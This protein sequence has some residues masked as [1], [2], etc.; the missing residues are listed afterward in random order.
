MQINNNEHLIFK[1]I[2]DGSSYIILF[3]ASF[4]FIE[5]LVRAFMLPLTLSF[6]L[7]R[8]DIVNE[9]LGGIEAANYAYQNIMGLGSV[10]VQVV[11][12]IF[13][14]FAIVAICNKV[15]VNDFNNFKVRIGNNIGMILVFG[16][17]IYVVDIIVSNVYAFLGEG[18]TSMNQLMI[19]GLLSSPARWLTI[20]LTVLLA[21]IVEEMVFRKFMFGV[22][23]DKLKFPIW[24]SGLLSAIVFA[25][26]HV[27][28]SLDQLI[29]FPQYFV[30]AIVLV[31]AYVY[32]KQNIW[33][34][35]G[36]HIFNNAVSVILWAISTLI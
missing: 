32:S 8:A 31:G 2:K 20:L 25:L 4:V 14:I 16:V 26:I 3:L 34:S 15:L 35:I 22:F 27:S 17:A 36:V 11:A 30:L 19:Y 9:I 7:K 13:F 23:F 5:F 28:S 24:L 1:R 33:F 29:Y 18:G 21:P 6:P 10:V 12:Y